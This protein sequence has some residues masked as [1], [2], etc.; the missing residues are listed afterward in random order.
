M[1]AGEDQPGHRVGG[2]AELEPVRRPDGEVGALARRDR[3]DVVACQHLGA[4][5]RSQPDRLPCSHRLRPAAP[6]RDEQRLLDV[7]EEVAAL[8]RRR[9]VDAEPDAHARLQ[10]RLHRRNARAEP[11]VRRGAVRDAGAGRREAADLG[12]GQVH[13]VRAP[14]VPVEPAERVEV[15]DR[16]AAV[17]LLA[18]RLLLD[19][20]RQVRV[21]LQ[22]EAPRELG[23]LRH[24]AAGD[25]E[26]RAGRDRDLDSR[27]RAGL[28]QLAGE[29]LGVGEHG[30]DLLD[31]LVGRQ[32]AVGGAEVHRAA[33][34][35]DAGS[36]APA[37]PAPP[38]RRAPSGR[39][40]RRSGG[41]R[42][43]CSPRASAPRARSARRRT[44]PRR[45][46]APTSGRARP[47]IRRA[48]PAARGRA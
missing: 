34:G 47:A 20:L 28:V 31:E 32:A 16:R 11:Q 48:W 41:R 33:G 29:A 4:A 9:P 39:A 30:V 3:A 25:R 45:R 38:P 46:S 40:G 15:L 22:A 14:D 10:H 37:P 23:R 43:S 44:P 36:R 2:A 42:R 27:A 35:D 8:V 13:A 24:Q 7:V 5:A 18:V 6:A 1:R 19:R 12:I 21:Q 26:R 17:Q